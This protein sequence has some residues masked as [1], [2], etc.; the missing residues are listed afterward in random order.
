MTSGGHAGFAPPPGVVAGPCSAMNALCAF[1]FIILFAVLPPSGVTPL[2]AEFVT[3]VPSAFAYDDGQYRYDGDETVDRSAESLRLDGIYAYDDRS[4][5]T[6]P[7][8]LAFAPVLAAKA[9]DGVPDAFVVVRGG[10]KDLPPPGEVFSGAAGRTLDDAGA[11]K[12]S[13]GSFHAPPN[14]SIALSGE[15]PE[16]CSATISAYGRLPGRVTRMS[17]RWPF[18]SANSCTPGLQSRR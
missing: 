9:G 10:T 16:P 1:A 3:A 2:H 8:A 12:T 15:P 4:N 17:T 13:P 18:R 7:R 5:L 11:R 6:Q 14:T